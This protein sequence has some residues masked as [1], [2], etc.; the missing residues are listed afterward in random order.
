MDVMELLPSNVA[1]SKL[2]ATEG[3]GRSEDTVVRRSMDA[4]VFSNLSATSCSSSQDT[5]NIE[6]PPEL[7]SVYSNKRQTDIEQSTPANVL[8]KSVLDNNTKKF[9]NGGR[10]SSLTR[11]PDSVGKQLRRKGGKVPRCDSPV[12]KKSRT[13]RGVESVG[14]V[15]VDDVV[16][17]SVENGLTC[18]SAGTR[19]EGSGLQFLTRGRIKDDGRGRRDRD[20]GGKC[21]RVQ[22]RRVRDREKGIIINGEGTRKGGRHGRRSRGGSPF[23]GGEARGVG[24]RVRPTFLG[25][26]RR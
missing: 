19:E 24:E 1:V 6:N 10:N 9:L 5:P 2:L 26:R 7:K 17:M 22:W 16:Q 14:L 15:K 4:P 20:A 25:R 3:F 12:L 11:L 13:D 18:A 21:L 23:P 8:N